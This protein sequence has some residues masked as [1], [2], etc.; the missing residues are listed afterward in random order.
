MYG[1]VPR[2]KCTDEGEESDA[3]VTGAK[4]RRFSV[5]HS[6]STGQVVFAITTHLM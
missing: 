5:G 2:G 3:V 1:I 6:N 4:Y